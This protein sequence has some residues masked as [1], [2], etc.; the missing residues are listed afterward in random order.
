MDSC[1]DEDYPVG[2]ASDF[3]AK[4]EVFCFELQSKDG[5]TLD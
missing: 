1:Q 3:L 2:F 5:L 4:D